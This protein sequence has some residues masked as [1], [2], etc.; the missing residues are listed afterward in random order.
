MELDENS[1]NNSAKVLHRVVLRSGNNSVLNLSGFELF[2]CLRETQTFPGVVLR[3]GN[4]SGEK[5]FRTKLFALAAVAGCPN[6]GFSLSYSAPA[7]ITQEKSRLELS[8]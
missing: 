3:S 4:N 8:C 2:C 6:A 7:E 5:S 1:G